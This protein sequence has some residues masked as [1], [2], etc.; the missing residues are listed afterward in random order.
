[1]CFLRSVFSSFRDPEFSSWN[2]PFIRRDYT[3]VQFSIIKFPEKIR[4]LEIFYLLINLALFCRQMPPVITL[5]LKYLRRVN[6]E[7]AIS[8]EHDYL[9]AQCISR[10]LNLDPLLLDFISG[11]AIDYIGRLFCL[12]YHRSVHFILHCSPSFFKF[13]RLVIFSVFF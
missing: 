9:L 2:I 12:L 3:V 6:D 4:S 10:Q 11:Y 7:N 1:M 13:K 5:L 8:A